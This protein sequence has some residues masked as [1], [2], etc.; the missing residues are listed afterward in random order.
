MS[1]TA[2]RGFV[3]AQH[4]VLA[5]YGLQ[6]ESRF[7]DLPVLGGPPTRSSPASDHP[8]CWSSEV[9]CLRSCGHR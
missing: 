8:C 3:A 7:V 2:Q 9:G 5:F 1:G 4:D 6:A